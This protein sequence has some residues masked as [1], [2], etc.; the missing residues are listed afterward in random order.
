MQ[1]SHDPA[2]VVVV[3]FLGSRIS[4]SYRDKRPS[5][6]SPQQYCRLFS[7]SARSIRRPLVRSILARLHGLLDLWLLEVLGNRLALVVC[8]A[9]TVETQQSTEVELGCLEQLDFSDVNIL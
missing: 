2:A 6:V 1:T 3:D 7:G 5:S 9:F 8:A 4:Q